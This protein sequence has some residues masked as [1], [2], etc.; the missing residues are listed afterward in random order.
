MTIRHVISSWFGFPRWGVGFKGLGKNGNM[1]MS[2]VC[3]H[4]CEW[5]ILRMWMSHV[6]H[7]DEWCHTFEWVIPHT[8]MSPMTHADASIRPFLENNWF[9]EEL[10]NLPF[11]HMYHPYIYAYVY[12]Y[13][14]ICTYIYIN[15]CIFIHV[16]GVL[17]CVSL[18]KS[19]TPLELRFSRG[20]SV[21]QRCSVLQCVAARVTVISSKERQVSASHSLTRRLSENLTHAHL[22]AHAHTQTHTHTHIHT[23]TN[24]NTHTRTLTHEDMQGRHPLVVYFLW[25]TQPVQ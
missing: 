23:H 9:Q 12:I 19:A 13:I 16:F 3:C 8:W 18:Q 1:K 10:Q 5:A 14:Y 25:W 20:T 17:L 7:V 15:M 22:H 6:S 21:L 11:L 24:T 2:H 4:T